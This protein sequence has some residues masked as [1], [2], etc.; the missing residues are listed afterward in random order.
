MYTS[1]QNYNP[2]NHW[3]V[4]LIG[5]LVLIPLI[6][7]I[8]ISVVFFFADN[9]G[10][11][12][13]VVGILFLYFTYDKKTTWLSMTPMEFIGITTFSILA[14]LGIVLVLLNGISFQSFSGIF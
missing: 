1:R 14:T 9:P 8:I 6:M 7:A 10:I 13:V 4:G 3:L 2:G 11:F 12:L 5:G